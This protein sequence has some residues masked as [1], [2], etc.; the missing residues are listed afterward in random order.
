MYS[1]ATGRSHASQPEI[2]CMFWCMFCL[3]FSAF[4]CD[5]MQNSNRLYV[6]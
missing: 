3:E 5:A 1:F 2:W 6:K 4:L